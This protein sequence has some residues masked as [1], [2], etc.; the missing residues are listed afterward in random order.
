M[1][2]SATGKYPL[3]LR[4]PAQVVSYV[5][6][7]LFIP[8]YIFIF[9]MKELPYEFAGITMWQLNM[10]LFGL[11][12][13]TAFFPAFAVFLLWRLKFSESIY[14]R[15]QKERIIP[16]VITMFFYWWMYY[17]SRN[18]TDQPAVLKFFF[19]GIFLST[20]VGLVINNYMKISL[21]AL[22]AGGGAAAIILFAYYYGA[23]FGLPISIAVLLAGLIC[24][25]R[26]LVSDHTTREIYTGVLTGAAL[27]LGAY[28][29]IM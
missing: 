20:S 12:W 19:M 21:H 4:L 15:S 13:L 25:S 5:F 23:P 2:Q 27:Q 10:R 22:G 14:L 1:E 29:F 8:T 26:L 17:L 18:F 24:T 7:P 3:A 28:W 16:F 11:F 6:H 9:L